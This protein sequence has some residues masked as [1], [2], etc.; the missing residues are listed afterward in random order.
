MKECIPPIITESKFRLVQKKRRSE[1]ISL[2]TMPVRIAV[3]RNTVQRRN[4]KIRICR[5]D[6]TDLIS[7][8]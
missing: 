3:V 5:F 7:I 2:R 1:A 4:R 8:K 6:K